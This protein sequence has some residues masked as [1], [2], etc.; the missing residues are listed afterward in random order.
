M[1]YSQQFTKLFIGC[2]RCPAVYEFPETYPAETDMRRVRLVL[3]EGW[4]ALGATATRHLC[5]QCAAAELTTE[6]EGR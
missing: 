4:R 3:P 6:E 2:D 5:P 1:R